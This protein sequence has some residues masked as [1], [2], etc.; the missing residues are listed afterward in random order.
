[1]A[2]PGGVLSCVLVELLCAS[3][4]DCTMMISNQ[5]LR[6]EMTTLQLVLNVVP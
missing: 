5:C 4:K 2:Q 3:M 1:M 6:H